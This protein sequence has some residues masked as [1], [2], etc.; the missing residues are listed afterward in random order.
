[1]TRQR[2]AFT[3]IGALNSDVNNDKAWSPRSDI[4]RK[5]G[6]RRI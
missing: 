5:Q 3:A 6:P 4:V 1:M 2:I